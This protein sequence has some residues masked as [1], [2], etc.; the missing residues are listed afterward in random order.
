MEFVGGDETLWREGRL[1][2][3]K[4]KVRGGKRREGFLKGKCRVVLD[5]R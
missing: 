5:I 2:G 3:D 1:R 4:E